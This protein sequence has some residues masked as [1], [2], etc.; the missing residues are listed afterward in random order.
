MLGSKGPPRGNGI[1]VSNGHATD[2][3][4]G[5]VRQVGRLS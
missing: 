2:D 4:K 3:V 5:T 1:W